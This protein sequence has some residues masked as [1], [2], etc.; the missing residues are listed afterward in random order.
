MATA[1]KETGGSNFKGRDVAADRKPTENTGDPRGQFGMFLR[2][3]LD[4]RSDRSEAKKGIAKAAGVEPRAVGKWEEGVAG[5]P[6]Q[7]LDAIAKEMGYAN[8]ATLAIAAVKHYESSR[9]K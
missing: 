1:T 2:H 5:P 6:L 9:G 8:W 7:S 4:R 3:W